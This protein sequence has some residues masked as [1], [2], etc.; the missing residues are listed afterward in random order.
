MQHSEHPDNYN[1]E[2]CD[3]CVQK[4]KE[5]RAFFKYLEIPVDFSVSSFTIGINGRML[6]KILTN[7]EKL[8]QLISKLKLKA[9][10]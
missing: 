1:Y 6:Y 4:A 2:Q 9:F 5:I 8:Q 7:P 10:W 3:G